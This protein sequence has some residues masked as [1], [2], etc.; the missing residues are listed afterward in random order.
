MYQQLLWG[1]AA[2]RLQLL[3]VLDCFRLK[4]LWKR[5]Y[6][7]CGYINNYAVDSCYIFRGKS[8]SHA[9]M[10]GK[11]AAV[12]I[13]EEEAK[14]LIKSREYKEKICILHT[15]S[16]FNNF[17]AFMS[18]YCSNKQPRKCYSIRRRISNRPN[19]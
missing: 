11:M 3:S 6:P 1:T 9:T 18:R 14:E 17:F 15:S 4:L 8:T 7:L 12:S 19:C 13:T 10:K 2:A 5:Q 16:L